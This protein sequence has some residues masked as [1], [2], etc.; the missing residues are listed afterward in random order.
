M[1]AWGDGGSIVESAAFLPNTNSLGLE[2]PRQL[3]LSLGAALFWQRKLWPRLRLGIV[4]R[5]LVEGEQ[6]N[7]GIGGTVPGPRLPRQ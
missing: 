2:L 3:E 5:N 4:A 1:G 6:V 7:M